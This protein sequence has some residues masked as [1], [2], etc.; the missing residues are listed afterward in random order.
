MLV[1]LCYL[2][3]MVEYHELS[4]VSITRVSQ[5]QVWCV[6]LTTSEILP[7]I[8]CVYHFPPLLWWL[9]GYFPHAL[10]LPV[11][12][13]SNRH[14][15]ILWSLNSVPTEDEYIT[16]H[17]HVICS[18]QPNSPMNNK[19]NFRYIVLKFQTCWHHLWI[20]VV[21]TPPFRWTSSLLRIS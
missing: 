1:L 5:A 13:V 16:W 14:F 18:L 6:T 11:R 7:Y 20:H 17:Y 9:H 4:R 3:C 8:H 21:C 15:K 19:K 12:T 2:S 10:L